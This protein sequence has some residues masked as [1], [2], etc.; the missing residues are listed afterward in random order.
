MRILIHLS[1]VSPI[2]TVK[3]HIRAGPNRV[4]IILTKFVGIFV[5]EFEIKRK[6]QTRI[7]SPL[8]FRLTGYWAIIGLLE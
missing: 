8:P 1:F 3:I 4:N 2:R 7:A 5:T 6:S